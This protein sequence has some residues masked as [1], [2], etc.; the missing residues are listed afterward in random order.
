MDARLFS[1]IEAR[2]L[3]FHPYIER[4]VLSMKDNTNLKVLETLYVGIDVSKNSNQTCILTFNGDKLCNFSSA[5]NTD[6]AKEIE[7]KILF[8]LSKHECKYVKVVLESTGIYSIHIANYLSSSESLIKFETEVFV[9][10]PVSTA[11]YSKVLNIPDKNDSKDAFALADYARSGHTK[12]LKPFRGTQRLALQRLTRH[13]KHV[14]ELLSAEKTYVLNNI[15]LKFSDYNNP[16]HMTECF[17]NTFSTTSLAILSK[18]K[19]PEQ[20]AN[21]KIEKLIDIIVDAGKNKFKNPDQI[22][23]TLKKAARSSY[24]LDKTSYDSLNIAIASS[25]ALIDCYE[26]QIKSIDEAIEKLVKGLDNQN[27]YKSLISIPGIGPVYAA[28]I[29]AEIGDVNIFKDD[30]ALAKY[31]GLIWK[32]HQSG[33][34]SADT[35]RLSKAGNSYLR[36]YII[37]AAGSVIY[38][39]SN[40]HQFYQKKFNEVTVHQHARALVLT[41][42]KL[43]RLIYGLM[44]KDQLYNPNK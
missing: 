37:E 14:V 38:C 32:E 23:E 18:F 20:L 29:L 30:S 41:A 25:L 35:T 31:I 5:H 6:G 9:V 13:R 36:Y 7:D 43:V 1:F 33:D 16:K 22:A 12:N 19:S 34:F 11:N 4:M 26:K 2:N 27:Q 39:E 21:C 15:F 42:R 8:L 10:N 17:S 40:Y 28:G 24:R 3:L 44:S